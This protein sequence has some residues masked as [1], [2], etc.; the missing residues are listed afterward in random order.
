MG[1]KGKLS[2]GSGES[3]GPAGATG[4]EPGTRHSGY[5]PRTVG[6]WEGSSGRE[7]AHFP[8]LLLQM[9]KTSPRAE[10]EPGGGLEHVCPSPRA[11]CRARGLGEQGESTAEA[12]AKPKAFRWQQE[13]THMTSPEKR[14]GDGL[15]KSR[16]ISY[17]WRR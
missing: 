9:G 10:E 1:L 15:N 5:R 7:E 13:G 16:D 14:H 4:Q 8:P 12:Q 11:K 3:G 6:C 17:S 2:P